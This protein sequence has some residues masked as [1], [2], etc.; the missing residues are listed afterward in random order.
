MCACDTVAVKVTSNPLFQLFQE[1]GRL[2]LAKVPVKFGGTDE[3]LVLIVYLDTQ[4]LRGAGLVE[5]T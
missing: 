3:E 2:K 5:A 1:D 4:S